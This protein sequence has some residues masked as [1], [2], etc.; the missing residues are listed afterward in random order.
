[1]LLRTE[2]AAQVSSLR[3]LPLVLW[4]CAH[5]AASRSLARRQHYGEACC[6]KRPRGLAR[7]EASQSPQSLCSSFNRW[8]RG[9]P[10]IMEGGGDLVGAPVASSKRSQDVEKVGFGGES[11]ETV[12]CDNSARNQSAAGIDDIILPPMRYNTCALS[13]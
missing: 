7:D 3:A 9:M 10:S 4:I 2:A 12:T 11:H 6:N 13:I 1:M 5:L 8:A